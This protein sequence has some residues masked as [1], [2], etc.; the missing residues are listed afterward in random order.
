M[1]NQTGK[2]GDGLSFLPTTMV[3]VG[4]KWWGHEQATKLL[5]QMFGT[6]DVPSLFYL[7]VVEGVTKRR[8]GKCDCN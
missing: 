7:F 5:G 2:K 6:E 8:G 1:N 3:L 4:L